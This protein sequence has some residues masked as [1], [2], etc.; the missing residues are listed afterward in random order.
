MIRKP[1]IPDTSQ[2]G[3]GE[4]LIENYRKNA[5]MPSLFARASHIHSH[6]QHTN[7]KKAVRPCF[8][9]WPPNHTNSLLFPPGPQYRPP[10]ESYTTQTFGCIFQTRRLI[11]CH[12]PPVSSYNNKPPPHKYSTNNNSSSCII[13]RASI[14]RLFEVSPWVLVQIAVTLRSGDSLQTYLSPS[15]INRTPEWDSTPPP[16]KLF[17]FHRSFLSIP[18]IFFIPLKTYIQK[19]IFYELVRAE[20]DPKKENP[21]CENA[22]WPICSAPHLLGCEHPTKKKKKGFFTSPSYSFIYRVP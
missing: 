11:E 18:L 1:I 3:G 7:P 17:P 6:M 22:F 14:S 21:S 15:H 12:Y 9:K 20:R 2:P 4:R 19:K 8:V 5:G 13:N 10:R 16:P